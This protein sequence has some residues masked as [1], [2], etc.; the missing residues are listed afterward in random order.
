MEILRKNIRLS[1]IRHNKTRPIDNPN[2]DHVFIEDS[3]V[4]DERIK[5]QN[6]ITDDC[7]LVAKELRKEFVGKRSI[8]TKFNFF[9]SQLLFSS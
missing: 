7:P 8:L 9:N 3:D 5:I 6:S 2:E 4:K 1:E